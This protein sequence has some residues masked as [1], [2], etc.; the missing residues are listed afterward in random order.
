MLIW[1]LLAIGLLLPTQMV[2]SRKLMDVS[3]S[4]Q[5]IAC[6]GWDFGCKKVT[7]RVPPSQRQRRVVTRL[8]PPLLSQ[9]RPS[10]TTLKP[11]PK[12][13]RLLLPPV[14]AMRWH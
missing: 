6:T 14:I 1:A 2:S 7:S 3:A 10:A 12:P 5:A 13:L 4:A 9:T 11:L 8:L